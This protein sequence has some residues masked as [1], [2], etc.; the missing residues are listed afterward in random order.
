MSVTKHVL[1]INQVMVRNGASIFPKRFKP[2]IQQIQYFQSQGIWKFPKHEYRK[3][4]IN[5]KHIFRAN[6]Y[7]H[8][9]LYITI[10]INN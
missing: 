7:Q 1:L 5:H 8:V 3:S 9:F 6:T 2:L 4:T 10:A